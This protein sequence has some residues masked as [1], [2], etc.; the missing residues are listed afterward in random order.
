M[1][2]VGGTILS[3][4]PVKAQSMMRHMAILLYLQMTH[5]LLIPPRLKKGNQI[6]I[7]KVLVVAFASVVGTVLKVGEAVEKEKKKDE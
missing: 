1:F 6:M 7:L 3:A 2:L 4:L 5:Y